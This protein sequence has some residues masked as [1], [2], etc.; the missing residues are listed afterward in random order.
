[1]SKVK[2]RINKKVCLICG[3]GHSGSTLLGLIL[4]SHESCFYA[5]EANK[6]QFLKDPDKEVKLRYCKLC[7]PNCPIW[8]HIEPQSE[9]DVYEQLSIITQKPIIIDST[10]NLGWLTKQISLLSKSR[11]RLYLI[12]IQRDGRAVINSRIRKY[13]NLDA[14]KLIED[15]K[16]QIQLTN[17]LFNTFMGKKIR[18]H[19]EE[20]AMNPSLIIRE[21]C[22]FLNIKFTPQ[23]IDY[24]LFNHHPLGGNTGTQFLITR[25]KQNPSFL[26][27]DTYHENYYADHSLRIK[28]DLRWKKELDPKIETLFNS[29]AS[30]LNGEF[31][32]DGN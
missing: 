8:S 32:F 11:A 12:Y 4:G 3:A 21:L 26:K 28:L 2:E 5:G 24:Y 1:M 14:L 15:W 25:A 18:I 7:G 16:N 31:E 27:L 19:Y 6:S 13:P 10:K 9:M 30:N 22:R 29:I 17:D 20:L 23:M